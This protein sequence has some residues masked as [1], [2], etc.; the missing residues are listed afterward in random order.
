MERVGAVTVIFPDDGTA[1][2]VLASRWGEPLLVVG[3]DDLAR[4]IWTDPDAWMRLVLEQHDGEARATFSPCVPAAEYIGRD[5]RF[6]FERH[7]ILGATPELLAMKWGP[8]FALD[9]GGET[10]RLDCPAVEVSESGATCSIGFAGDKAVR[11]TVTIDHRLDP[12]GGPNVFAA[13]KD[14]LGELRKQWGDERGNTWIFDRGYTV[15]QVPGTPAITV[16]RV[17]R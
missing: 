3:H 13:L 11:F 16:E 8:R 17:A 10:G 7:P 12:D 5:G 2:R 4:R 1:A 14:R 6:A 9:A 15:T